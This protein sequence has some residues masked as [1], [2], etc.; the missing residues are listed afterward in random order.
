MGHFSLAYLE[1]VINFSP[2]IEEYRKHINLV[3]D[4]LR[5]HNLKIKI[6]KCKF[7]QS[8]TQYLGFIVD[9]KG[10]QPDP[11]KIKVMRAILPPENVRE[12]QGILG[13]CSYYTHFIPNF[14]EIVIPLI[15]LT[16]KFVKFVWSEE[17]H[18]AFIFLKTSLTTVPI[19]GYPYVNKPYILYTDTSDNWRMLVPTM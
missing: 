1:D 13:M 7:M 19:L 3:F 18:A 15:K 6:S 9:N 12:V 2:S 8:E 14:S 10:I 16:K 11:E 4:Q 17:Y 5:E